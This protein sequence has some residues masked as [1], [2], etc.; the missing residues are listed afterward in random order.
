MRNNTKHLKFF[1]TY[2]TA[3]LIE[4]WATN[5]D[6]FIEVPWEYSSTSESVC[7]F[8]KIT[9][10]H[11]YIYAALATSKRRDYRKNEDLYMP[12]DTK[13]LLPIFDNYKIQL[14]S[15][16]DFDP[17]DEWGGIEEYE[18]FYQWFL[19][20]EKS[21]EL[22]WEHITE[23]VFHLLFANRGFLLTFNTSLAAYL[24]QGEVAL[25]K[26][27]LDSKGRIRR[28]SYTPT[29]VRKAVYYRDHGR[30][31]ICHKDLSGL[32]GTDRV[33]HYDHMVPLNLHG[34]N[35]PTNLQLLCAECNLRKGGDI[36]QTGIRY[37][38]WW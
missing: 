23:E 32:L 30:C 35:D 27:N 28:Q 36:S 5:P 25:P 4:A 15:E 16:D 6:S 17:A 14:Q 26:G 33:L 24:R 21:F 34:V 10:L 37:P 3:S 12:E 29:W 1:E 11:Y 22:L 38:A 19:F 13:A 20:H 2:E 8:S 18:Y 31:V 9:I 7:R